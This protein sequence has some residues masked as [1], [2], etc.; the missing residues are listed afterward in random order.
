M[1]GLEYLELRNQCYNQQHIYPYATLI[2]S[3]YFRFAPL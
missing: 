2:I 1:I 3:I